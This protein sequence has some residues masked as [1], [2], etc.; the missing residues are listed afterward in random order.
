LSSFW[1]NLCVAAQALKKLRRE[2][3]SPRWRRPIAAQKET[4]AVA[5][6]FRRASKTG[7]VVRPEIT[8]PETKLQ[9]KKW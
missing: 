6:P 7:G 5:A 8:T 9:L 2:L 3:I 1:I 4:P